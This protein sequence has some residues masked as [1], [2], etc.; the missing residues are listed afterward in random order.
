MIASYIIID[1]ELAIGADQGRAQ[2][3]VVY[4]C[5]DRVL[6]GD[7]VAHPDIFGG[8]IIALDLHSIGYT[9]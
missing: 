8:S 1:L 9:V 4:L 6:G 5:S 7:H 2:T 3:R